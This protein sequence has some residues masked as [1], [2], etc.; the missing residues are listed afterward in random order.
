MRELTEEE[1]GSIRGRG[2]VPTGPDSSVDRYIPLLVTSTATELLQDWRHPE[3]SCFSYALSDQGD[4]PRSL[5]T[6]AI[7]TK[8][9]IS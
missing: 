7:V 9:A 6:V 2:T 5:E 3:G 4:V 1:E 8:S